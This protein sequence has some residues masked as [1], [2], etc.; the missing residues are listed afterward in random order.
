MPEYGFPLTR[1]FPYKDKIYDYV[2]IRED[3][4]QRKPVFWNILHSESLTLGNT[5]EQLISNKKLMCCHILLTSLTPSPILTDISFVLSFHRN[6]AIFRHSRENGWKTLIPRPHPV[7]S[8]LWNISVLETVYALLR[9]SRENSPAVKFVG[10]GMFFN[11]KK[12]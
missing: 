1:I 10:P 11:L 2:F 6:A 5:C 9:R 8:K 4:G 7:N 12:L 3:T